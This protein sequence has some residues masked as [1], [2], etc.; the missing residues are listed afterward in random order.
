MSCMKASI[1]NQFNLNEGGISCLHEKWE[2]LVVKLSLTYRNEYSVTAVRIMMIP[3]QIV[4][5]D[6]CKKRDKGRVGEAV[7]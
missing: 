1:F 5:V 4:G 7:M 3:M 6:F 2:V